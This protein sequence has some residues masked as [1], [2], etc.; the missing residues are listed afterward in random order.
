MSRCYT[1]SERLLVS[2]A[3]AWELGG[4]FGDIAR[5]AGGIPRPAMMASCFAIGLSI[6]FTVRAWFHMFDEG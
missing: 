1:S 2:L 6:G 5:K 3:L 4:I